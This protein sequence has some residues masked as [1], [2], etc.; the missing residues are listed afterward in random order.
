MSR[1]AS[2]KYA[3]P[4][5]RV[6]PATIPP[7]GRLALVT[8][9]SPYREEGYLERALATL[10]ELGFA[11]SLGPH[12]GQAHGYLAGT[13]QQRASDLHAAFADP[14]VDA[15][16]AVRGGYGA[17]EL[18]PLLDEALLRANPKPFIGMSDLTV[19]HLVLGERL[20]LPTFWGPMAGQ[21]ARG[22]DYTRRMFHAVLTR[23]PAAGPLELPEEAVVTTLVPGSAAGPLGGGTTALLAASLGTAWEVQ[24]EGRVVLLEDVGL[25]PYE[26]DRA[27]LQLLQAG[28]LADAA[29]FAIGVHVGV[30]P[31]DRA[32]SLNLMEVLERHLAPLG[33]PTVYGL[34][35]GHARDL[36]TVRYGAPVRLD[37]SAGSLELL[38]SSSAR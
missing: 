17:A 10:T 36:A 37:A 33:L 6:Q 38:N 2:A 3:Q 26:L 5:T 27:L 4:R 12:V 31:R 34:P 7:G 28:K 15:V 30:A 24:T 1:I 25:E 32:P 8:P 9:S 23:G 11:T 29:A 35:L 21:L 16:L 19:L 14:E 22:T 18:V 20:G 13:A